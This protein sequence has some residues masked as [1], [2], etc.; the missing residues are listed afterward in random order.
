MIIFMICVWFEQ[1]LIS[2]LSNLVLVYLVISY[3]SRVDY[4][5]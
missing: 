1:V 4:L 3:H 2:D 5:L